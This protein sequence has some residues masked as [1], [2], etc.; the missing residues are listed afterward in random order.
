MSKLYTKLPF[1][2]YEISEIAWSPGSDV[3]A[4]TYKGIISEV[5]QTVQLSL[6]AMDD[7][8]PTFE[9]CLHCA[10]LMTEGFDNQAAE[11]AHKMK[12]WA[13]W[14]FG[15]RAEDCVLLDGQGGAF[16]ENIASVHR[17]RVG[18]KNPP[19]YRVCLLS[20]GSEQIIDARLLDANVPGFIALQDL[21]IKHHLAEDT[22]LDLLSTMTR[23]LSYQALKKN[24]Q[25]FIDQL[26]TCVPL[27]LSNAELVK[28]L[29]GSINQTPETFA[30]LPDMTSE[31]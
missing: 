31:T 29:V 13:G 22:V 7:A 20:Q 21:L 6:T 2:V 9:R 14:F 24:T 11:I 26:N 3:C 1:S 12:A 16:W 28:V 25:L 8:C 4:V 15:K 23:H 30:A 10:M 5:T 18:K 17:T 19:S 27:G